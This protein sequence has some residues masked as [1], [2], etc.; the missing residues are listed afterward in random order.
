MIFNLQKKG[1]KPIYEYL[2]ESI[3]ND[4]ISG[5]LKSGD[6]LPSRRQ[7]ALDNG[8]YS[9]TGVLYGEFT[10]FPDRLVLHERL[11]S[12]PII[13]HVSPTCRNPAPCACTTFPSVSYQRSPFLMVTQSPFFAKAMLAK[14]SM[15]MNAFVL[16]IVLMV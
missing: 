9:P 6:K 7:M 5:K 14:H 11:L 2:Y 12:S 4:I 10:L 16:F 15:M 1:D 13:Y 8:S 3:R